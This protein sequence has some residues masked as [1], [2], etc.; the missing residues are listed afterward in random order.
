MP[1]DLPAVDRAR[2]KLSAKIQKQMASNDAVTQARI[3]DH[4]TDASIAGMAS[5]LRLAIPDVERQRTA[6]NSAAMWYFLMARTFSTSGI[7]PT[8][9]ARLLKTVENQATQL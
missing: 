2:F 5:R 3:P 8:K 4:Y 6:L 1:G 7:S 9:R